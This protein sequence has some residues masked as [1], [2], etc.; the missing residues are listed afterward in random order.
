MTTY[1]PSPMNIGMN[2]PAGEL[3]EPSRD[4]VVHT[5]IGTKQA[6]YAGK[7]VQYDMTLRC[8]LTKRK[9]IVSK[10]YSAVLDFRT[11]L[12]GLF[13]LFK[14]AGGDL[15]DPLAIQMNVLLDIPFPPKRLDPEASWVI[16]ER[17]QAFQIFFHEL[18]MT[19]AHL[20][21]LESEIAPFWAKFVKLVRFFLCVPSDM[22]TMN[23]ERLQQEANDTECSI[24]LVPFTKDDYH[25]PGV[26]IQT[27]CHHIFHQ[28][29]LAEWMESAITCPIC[30]HRIEGITGIYM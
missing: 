20:C 2:S 27:Q 18:L 5:S 7:Y 12:Y 25:V 4:V 24:C 11:A 15:N 23:F 10:R 3:L 1:A 21:S 28:G 17:S 29:C 19:K 26:I 13:L 6:G 22:L 14:R 9:W 8:P 16:D 30:R